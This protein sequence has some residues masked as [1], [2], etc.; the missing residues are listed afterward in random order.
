LDSI[1]TN[2]GLDYLDATSSFE[3][4][5]I[6]EYSIYPTDNHPNSKANLVFASVIREYLNEN[7]LLEC[8]VRHE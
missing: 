3:G 7:K 8:G 2:S 1:V 5:K 4:A 6:S